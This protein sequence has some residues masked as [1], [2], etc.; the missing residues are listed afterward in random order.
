MRACLKMKKLLALIA[1]FLCLSQ[2]L[3]AQ[4][5]MTVMPFQGFVSDLSG[6]PLNGA[7]TLTFKFYANLNDA[8]P[9][10]TETLANVPVQFGAFSV[11]LGEQNPALKDAL[12]EGF[13]KFIGI[14]VNQGAE[15]LPR[16]KLG[17]VPYA[18]LSNNALSLGGKAYTEFLTQDALVTEIPQI[19]NQTVQQSQQNLQQTI[20]ETVQQTV[21]QNI[22]N[23]NQ[24]LTE[25]QVNQLIDSRNYVTQNEVQNLV[26]Q[27]IQQVNQTVG[28]TEAQ[29]NQLIDS[30]GFATLPTVQ[31]W[32]GTQNFLNQNQMIAWV[33]SQSFAT[34]PTVQTW[35]LDQDYVNA[36][37]VQN[38][39][40]TSMQ[41]AGG[42]GLDTNAVNALIDAR[43]YLTQNAIQALINA[44]VAVVQNA[45]NTLTLTVNQHTNQIQTI[46]GNLV[47]L[48]DKDTFLQNK[49]NDLTTLYNDLNAKYTTLNNQHVTLQANYDAQQVTINTLNTQLTALTAQFN[50]LNTQVNTLNTQ[51]NTL[52]T[53]VTT[54]SNQTTTPAIPEIVGVSATTS[55]K[56]SVGGKIGI[57]GATELCKASFA[58]SHACST[59]EAH[60]AIS[61]NKYPANIV[62]TATWVSDPTLEAANQFSANNAFTGAKFC[63]SLQYNSGDVAVGTTMLIRSFTSGGGG[64]GVTG[65]HLAFNLN[66]SCAGSYPIM[67]CK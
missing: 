64:G 60:V 43:G 1:L 65:V 34:L 5:P 38:M 19:V 46:N 63:Q 13:A 57:Q 36:T 18:F 3:S 40:N 28:L 11:Q 67:C 42:G 35:V 7:V 17:A 21:Q 24:G 12:N 49:I 66:V 52:N 32:V 62:G 25:A 55:G 48:V 31:T 20:Q 26:V 16:Q 30:K 10:W 59:N 14:S 58:N 61:A 8:Q 47:T 37:D 15:M 56:I 53:Q 6:S 22:Q 23:I 45:L 44:S 51:V 29:V 27:Q 2:P 41:N 33:N 4:Q 54:L 39:I 9:L 50:T